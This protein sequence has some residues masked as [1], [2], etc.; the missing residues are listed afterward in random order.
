MLVHFQSGKRQVIAQFAGGF[1]FQIKL[2]SDA[3][4]H[5]WPPFT[6]PYRY[7]AL[8][9]FGENYMVNDLV[10]G[11]LYQHYKGQKYIVKDVARHSET[12]ELVVVYECQYDNPKGKLWVRP[13]EMFLESVEVEG[14]MVRRFKSIKA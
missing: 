8:F 2:I 7:Y 9:I 6:L 11:G 13:L 5:C 3:P 14:Q 1:R 4:L 12:L 10:I